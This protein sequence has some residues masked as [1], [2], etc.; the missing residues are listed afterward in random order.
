MSLQGLIIVIFIPTVSVKE[1]PADLTDGSNANPYASIGP[2][3]ESSEIANR[4]GN[5]EEVASFGMKKTSGADTR[6][7]EGG[8]QQAA[9]QSNEIQIP[10][11]NVPSP[12]A[13][14]SASQQATSP[15]VE[16]KNPAATGLPIMF[17]KNGP[18]L[19]P[20]YNNN[21]GVAGAG[22][23]SN[24][25]VSSMIENPSATPAML[26]QQEFPQPQQQQF[27]APPS[28]GQT[29]IIPMMGSFDRNSNHNN[30]NEVQGDS[31]CDV[32][33]APPCE[34]AEQQQQHQHQ[35]HQ[36][37]IEPEGMTSDMKATG[38]MIDRLIHTPGF[39]QLAS[40]LISEGRVNYDGGDGAD[41]TDDAIGPMG[42]DSGDSRN[43]V[44][45]RGNKI[46][47]FDHAQVNFDMKG[48][49]ATPNLPSSSSAA[50]DPGM[51]QEEEFRHR[52][53]ERHR[54]DIEA[55][56][57]H[58]PRSKSD[59]SNSNN[60]YD[61]YS[62]SRSRSK[63]RS[64]SSPSGLDGRYVNDISDPTEGIETKF[65]SKSADELL[66]YA[67]F[68]SLTA[69][70]LHAVGP[71]IDSPESQFA[72]P[73]PENTIEPPQLQN[74]GGAGE[75]ERASGRDEIERQYMNE[76]PSAL[77]DD[78]HKSQMQQGLSGPGESLRAGIGGVMEQEESESQ[79]RI[80]NPEPAPDDLLEQVRKFNHKM[81]NEQLQH[82]Q[83]IEAEKRNLNRGGLG[84][85]D[86]SS[87]DV[88]RN[89]GFSQQFEVQRKDLATENDLQLLNGRSAS[90]SSRV[91]SP[92]N[93]G[94]ISVMSGNAVQFKSGRM[95]MDNNNVAEEGEYSRN[96]IGRP[97]RRH[98]SKH[99][100]RH[101]N[102]NRIIRNKNRHFVHPYTRGIIEHP[103]VNRPFTENSDNDIELRVNGQT[104]TDNTQLRST[105]VNGRVRP[106]KGK[107]FTSKEPVQI[108]L[109]H[110]DDKRKIIN[111]VTKGKYRVMSDKKRFSIPH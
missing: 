60:D 105:I 24:P 1:I 27:E 93:F 94:Q 48:N 106:G 39:P 102:N 21:K 91:S 15:S 90:A 108:E 19:I 104:L 25:A 30:E 50:T 45:V 89:D 7:I 100:K 64:S 68:K 88:I 35:Q 96:T 61:G 23:V 69:S 97:R 70:D 101:N 44:P 78:L 95:S 62:S 59:V 38:E 14:S 43:V 36:Q 86:P 81:V 85:M 3:K 76:D 16:G 31:R 12:N 26:S 65:Q 74:I 109:S 71:G 63:G 79:H 87:A 72:P 49:Y 2:P 83:R 57:N 22:A 41:G 11:G 29:N 99:R 53:E 111:I 51:F 82:R 80:L 8:E 66:D 52:D 46:D 9:S 17:I 18:N 107:T 28:D 5:T 58:Q 67:K 98:H 73:P 4:T 92:H 20:V 75:D 56:L 47:S 103:M 37:Y 40:K 32:P 33:G 110:G 13:P 6:N 34:G 77:L 84:G 10:I 55:F 54:K 42:P